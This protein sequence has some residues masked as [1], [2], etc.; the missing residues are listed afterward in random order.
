MM[1]DFRVATTESFCFWVQRSTLVTTMNVGSFKAMARA[2]CS[3]VIRCTPTTPD[4][5]RMA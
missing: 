1:M 3:R 4:T 2:K 5:M